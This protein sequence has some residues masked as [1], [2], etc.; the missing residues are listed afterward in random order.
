[1]LAYVIFEVAAIAFAAFSVRRAFLI[2]RSP[3]AFERELRRSAFASR[4]SSFG[5]GLMRGCVPFAG[6]WVAMAIFAPVEIT[7]EWEATQGKALPGAMLVSGILLGLFVLGV[8]LQLTIA[9]FN[10]PRFLIPRYLR[11]GEAF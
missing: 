1:M 11:K 6:A 3:S 5:T 4:G 9:L 10:R 8:A 7:R 2:W